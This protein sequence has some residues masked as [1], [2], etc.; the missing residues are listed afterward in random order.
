MAKAMGVSVVACSRGKSNKC[1]FGGE[2]TLLSF[3]KM[4]IFNLNSDP[5]W[6]LRYLEEVKCSD[7]NVSVVHFE[8]QQ[9]KYFDMALKQCR[10]VIYCHPLLFSNNLFHNFP[11]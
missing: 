3:G 8:K 9:I 1:Y 7:N 11:M 2:S 10:Q 5:L 6:V 4:K